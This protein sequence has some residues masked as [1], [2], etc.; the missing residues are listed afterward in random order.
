MLIVKK[1]TNTEMSKGSSSGTRQ[2]AP[3]SPES[4]PGVAASLKEGPGE[5]SALLRASHTRHVQRHGEYSP[6]QATFP[7]VSS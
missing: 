2:K 1:Q 6:N 7:V 4:P 3:S 5:G